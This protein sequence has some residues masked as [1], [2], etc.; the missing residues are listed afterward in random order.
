[1]GWDRS[2]RFLAH[3]PRR[4]GIQSSTKHKYLLR[5]TAPLHAVSHDAAPNMVRRCVVRARPRTPLRAAEDVP[6]HRP[7]LFF[8]IGIVHP[9]R[10]M[11]S[12]MNAELRVSTGHQDESHVGRVSQG[13]DRVNAGGSEESMA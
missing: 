10:Q 11:P 6:P 4:Q 7:D 2:S 9:A 8:T 12:P 3:L 5:T 13:D 1:M